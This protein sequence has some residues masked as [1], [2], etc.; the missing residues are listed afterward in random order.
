MDNL[1]DNDIKQLIDIKE[2]YLNQQ[3]RNKEA[4]K[5]WNEANIDRVKEY[6]KEYYVLHSDK[7]K[8]KAIERAKNKSN[9]IKCE[10]CDA[11]VKQYSMRLHVSSKKHINAAK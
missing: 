7:L 5:R 6:K 4:V 8:E 1:S 9:Y 10:V 2:K 11:Q 3:R